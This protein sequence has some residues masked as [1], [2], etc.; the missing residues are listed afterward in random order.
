VN[1][2]FVCNPNGQYHIHPFDAHL[3]IA[4]VCM[5]RAVWS[6]FPHH[7]IIEANSAVKEYLENS[8]VKVTKSDSLGS[9][10]F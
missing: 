2:G 1:L 5:N 9:I 3:R 10:M 8:W 7:L 6:I 4:I